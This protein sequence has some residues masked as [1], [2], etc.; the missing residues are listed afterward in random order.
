M[1]L[2]SR[3][4]SATFTHTLARVKRRT[5]IRVTCKICGESRTMSTWDGSLQRWE[6]THRC[7]KARTAAKS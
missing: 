4:V 1:A 5:V 3:S 7:A 2:V 6:Q